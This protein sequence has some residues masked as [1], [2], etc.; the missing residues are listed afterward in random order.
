M[1]RK[2]KNEIKRL[3][4]GQEGL[5]KLELFQRKLEKW[6]KVHK[7]TNYGREGIWE[8]ILDS[9]YPFFH[10]KIEKGVMVDVGTGA[11]FPGLVVGLVYPQLKV[12]LVEPL[13][14]RYSFLSYLKN[15]TNSSNIQIYPVRVE[16]L[17]TSQPIDLITSRAV[18]D[19]QLLQKLTSHLWGENTRYLF[20]KGSKTPPPSFSYSQLNRGKRVYYLSI[21]ILRGKKEDNKK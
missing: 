18:G 9:I 20:Y 4:I 11:G 13:K 21:P 14:K 12:K 8:Q 1:N 5:E 15:L 19:Y 6:N 17:S 16:N 2:W 10:W 7:I 3:G